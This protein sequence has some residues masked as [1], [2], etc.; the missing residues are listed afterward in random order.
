[1]ARRLLFLVPAIK[2]PPETG[3]EHYNL[4]LADGLSQ[5]WDITT[6]GF[7]DIGLADR[8][9]AAYLN[10]L[11]GYLEARAPFDAIVQDTYVYPFAATANRWLAMQAP[12][13]GF[14]QAVYS[15]R[16]ARLWARWRENRKMAAGFRDYRG[17]I[18]VSE[19]MRKHALTIGFAPENLRMVYPGYD[20]RER[21][22][23]PIARPDDKIRIV[24]AGS[25][26]PAK[27]QHLIVEGVA[28]LLQRRPEL[29]PRLNVRIFGNQGYAP[30]Y[31]SRVRALIA[32]HRLE[33]VVQAEGPVPQNE[34]WRRFSE[35]HFFAFVS[36]GEGVG[37]VTVEAM[38]CGCV[39]LLTQD[40]LSNELTGGQTGELVS[41]DPAAVAA[42]LGRLL[43][44]FATW[45]EEAGRAQAQGTRNAPTWNDAISQFSRSVR[46]LAGIPADILP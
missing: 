31:V 37:M 17:M 25:Y 5:D 21:P 15:E 7:E 34:V 16:Y 32:T 14:G 12:L 22:P 41:R 33:D 45:P 10:A 36:E 44:R 3:G 38:L 39:P 20:L 4:R 11:R 19:A 9:E 43:D 27:G 2:R 18:V 26:Q 23:A 29:R 13:V 28:Q 46:E 30:S 6:A 1:M 8:T 42:G 24:T 40:S 35:S